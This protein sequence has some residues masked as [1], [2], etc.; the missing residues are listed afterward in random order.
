MYQ[1]QQSPNF[2]ETLPA[3][4]AKDKHNYNTRLTTHNILDIPLTKSNM[5][6]KI[7]IKTIA[8][9]IGTIW[10]K[11]LSDIPDSEFAVHHNQ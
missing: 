10:K 1:T 4:Y 11:D 6:G 8:L 7:S 3:L 2:S 5:Y 9:E